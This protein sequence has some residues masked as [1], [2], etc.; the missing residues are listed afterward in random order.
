MNNHYAQINAGGICVALL[1]SS[2]TTNAANMVAIA[3]G[4]AKLGQ[5]W[6]GAAWEDV[7]PN[8]KDLARA[9]LAQVDAETG[10]SRLLRETLIALADK[11]G[12]VVTFLKAKEAEAA[13]ERAKL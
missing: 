11:N 1:A 2:G 4:A 7:A 8:A 10:M 13:A 6:T 3:E 12:T 5:R 9:K